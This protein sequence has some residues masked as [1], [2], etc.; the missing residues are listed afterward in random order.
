ML[1]AEAT[2]AVVR[3]TEALYASIQA[4][5]GTVP[6]G[7]LDEARAEAETF[8][9]AVFCYQ[10]RC[11][12]RYFLS[13]EMEQEFGLLAHFIVAG[14]LF[15][16]GWSVLEE[17]L[18]AAQFLLIYNVLKDAES[19]MEGVADKLKELPQAYAAIKTIAD[20]LNAGDVGDDEVVAKAAAEDVW[21]RGKRALLAFA[22]RKPVQDDDDDT[23]FLAR[24]RG[25][26][27]RLVG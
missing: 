10:K 18:T 17:D 24:V 11:G 3:A 16:M 9:V 27:K 4:R 6:D 23:S 20:V 1:F 5:A 21:T 14:A 8:S 7:N 2:A 15:Y 26:G 25:A 13:M 22:H 19:T 12:V